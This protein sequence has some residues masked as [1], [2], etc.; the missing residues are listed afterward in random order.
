LDWT[1][2]SQKKLNLHK[3]SGKLN[4]Y[5]Q[6]MDNDSPIN[7]IALILERHNIWEARK[8]MPSLDVWKNI[9]MMVG[10]CKFGNIPNFRV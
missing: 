9:A 1:A 3:K 7:R 4:I 6:E 10:T 5:I 8:D 2:N